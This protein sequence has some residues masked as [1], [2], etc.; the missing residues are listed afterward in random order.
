M[1]L[2]QN[3]LVTFLHKRCDVW[4]GANLLDDSGHIVTRRVRGRVRRS[5][6]KVASALPSQILGKI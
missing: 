4:L 3:Y 6:G 2:E 1:L 5:V